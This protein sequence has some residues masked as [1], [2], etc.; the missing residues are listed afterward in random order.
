MTNKHSSTIKDVAEKAGVSETTVSLSF[1]PT[2][3]ISEKTRTRILAI[4]QELN[5][6]PNSV[7]QNLRVGRTKT[8]GFIVNDI[9]ESFYSIMSR[10]ATDVAYNYGYQLLYA[11][12]GWSPEKAIES[13]KSLLAQ[14]VEGLVLC[15]CE[16]ESESVELINSLHL[17]HIVVDTS[18][19]FYKGPYVINNE[20]SIGEIAGAHFIEQGCRRIA[21]FNASKE[22]STFSSFSQQLAGLK[23]AIGKSGITLH[24]KDV[25]Y[26]GISIEDG[27]AAFKRLHER[28]MSYDGI[29]CI[30]DEVAYGVIQEAEHNGLRVGKDIAIIGIDNLKTSS[31]DRISLTSIHMNYELMTT[32]AV[33]TLINGI[34]SGRE[35]TSRIVLEPE[36]IVRSSSSLARPI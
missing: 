21:F 35:I 14:R 27:M 17:P 20:F 11:E 15:L 25:V 3:R 4:A 19:D 29:L 6:V 9:T 7:A 8:I 16:K 24:S 23:S 26:A 12:T 33:N 34:E 10:T 2:S 31:L 28:G 1:K 30:N 32:L 36:L 13:T 18:P 22:M 5:Y